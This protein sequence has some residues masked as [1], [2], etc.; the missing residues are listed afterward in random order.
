MNADGLQIA[1]FSIA[2]VPFV[3]GMVGLRHR[4]TGHRLSESFLGLSLLAIVAE[5][6][7]T[8]LRVSGVLLSVPVVALGLFVIWQSD[9][10]L[11]DLAVLSI[12]LGIGL[13]IAYAI[14]AVLHPD[15]GSYADQGAIALA[16]LG[17]LLSFI[18]ITLTRS[19]PVWRGP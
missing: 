3:I 9:W 16:G 13:G 18:V 17:V 14:E 4:V 6:V 11:G 12:I 8:T 5:V 1:V 2:L 10:R 15:T 19:L 7:G